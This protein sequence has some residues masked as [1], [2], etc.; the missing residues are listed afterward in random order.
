MERKACT[1]FGETGLGETGFGEMG[2]S[3]TGRHH[4]SH[5]SRVTMACFVTYLQVVIVV[6][7]ICQFSCFPWN[8][9]S[10]VDETTLGPLWGPRIIGVERKDMYAAYD[11]FLLFSLFV[12]RLLLKASAAR[13]LNK[14][15]LDI[16]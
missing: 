5:T 1:A 7:Y 16:S 14:S 8:D 9:V 10:D 6:K 11:F 13:Y 4:L 2:F 3:K 12:H 15:I